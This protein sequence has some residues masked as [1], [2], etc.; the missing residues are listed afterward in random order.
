MGEGHSLADP[1]QALPQTSV[2]KPMSARM[3]HTIVGF[4]PQALIGDKKMM[5]AALEEMHVDLD[6]MP[7]GSISELQISRGYAALTDLAGAQRERD[8]EREVG[9][10]G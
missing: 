10:K 5:A 9:V 7:L 6:K 2:G 4:L 1:N 3:W 8:R